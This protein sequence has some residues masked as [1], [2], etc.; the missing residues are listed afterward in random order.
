MA[1]NDQGVTVTQAG[2]GA[3]PE[4]VVLGAETPE[5]DVSNPLGEQ[6]I[7]VKVREGVEFR[8][9]GVL[10]KSG[11]EFDMPISMARAASLYVDQVTEKGLRSVPHEQQQINVSGQTTNF[12]GMARHERIGALEGEEK[13][14]NAR[15]EQVRSQLEHERR[16]LEA[17]K[18]APAKDPGAA[19]AGTVNAPSKPA[20]VPQTQANTNPVRPADTAMGAANSGPE[21]RTK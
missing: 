20:D 19:P 5:Q 13:D 12:A 18:A 10:R 17:S 9:Q 16:A 6:T 1:T 8:N 4:T 3:Q 7:R 15:L 2:D 14:L 11:D 21:A